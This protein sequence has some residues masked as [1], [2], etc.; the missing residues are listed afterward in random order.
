MWRRPAGVGEAAEPW[1]A[2][3]AHEDVCGVEAPVHHPDVVEVGQR[4]RDGSAETGDG[5]DRAAPVRDGIT[6][7]PG[8]DLDAGTPLDAVL[9]PILGAAVG[10]GLVDAPRGGPD[11]RDE[12]GMAGAFEALGLEAKPGD[13]VGTGGGL[14]RD[15]PLGVERD[16]HL[17][18]H[19]VEYA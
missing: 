19:R 1:P 16:G 4:G 13:V 2:V 10:P 17:H 3:V 7:E 18:T 8:A 15:G 14:D 11:D 6:R 9:G 5:A 12:P